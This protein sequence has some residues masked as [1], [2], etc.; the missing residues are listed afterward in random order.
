[1]KKYFLLLL[2]PFVIAC[3]RE[4]EKKAQDL[5]AKNDSLMSQT[6]QKDEAI[7]EFIASINDIQGTLDTIS[8]AFE[9]LLDSFYQSTAMDVSTDISV[10]KN[11]FAQ[12]GLVD[13]GLKQE[14]TKDE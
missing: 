10:M 8:G 4:A 6:L 9:K 12:D 11:L 1:M 5:Q 13:D 3:G 7:N 14:G 2:V